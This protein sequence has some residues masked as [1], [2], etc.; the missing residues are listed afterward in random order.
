[1]GTSTRR[2]RK[3]KQ[4]LDPGDPPYEHEHTRMELD[5]HADTCALGK[6]CLILGDTGKTIDVGGYTKKLG[7]MKD[8]PI[9]HAAVAYD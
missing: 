6:G 1:M 2:K 4:S 5:S 8:I 3:R 9:V 7:A